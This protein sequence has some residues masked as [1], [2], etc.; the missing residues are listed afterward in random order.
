M[1][2]ANTIKTPAS[3]IKRVL[4]GIIDL[5]ILFVPNILLAF[6]F[7]NQS[8]QFVIQL[9]LHALYFSCF[10]GSNWHATP[11]KKVLSLM[12]EKN[13]GE[14]L[15]YGRA[16]FRWLCPNILYIL[17][18]LALLIVLA[19]IAGLVWMLHKHATFQSLFSSIE[20]SLAANHPWI[21][22]MCVIL[23]FTSVIPTVLYILPS[24]FTPDKL[25]GNDWM[26]NTRVVNYTTKE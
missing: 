18:V 19:L 26:S 7:K 14:P 10:E 2:N 23:F 9:L 1:E 21:I 6:I 25:L 4:A 8:H 13:N 17:Y 5:G 15:S 3:I 11:G 24:F 22:T 16:F 12:V 20:S